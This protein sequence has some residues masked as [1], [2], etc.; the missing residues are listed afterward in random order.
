MRNHAP[1]RHIGARLLNG[2]RF[3]FLVDLVEYRNRL[4]HKTFTRQLAPTYP[5]WCPPGSGSTRAPYSSAKA[6]PIARA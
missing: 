1:S 5:I 4:I 6:N 2:P 3:Y